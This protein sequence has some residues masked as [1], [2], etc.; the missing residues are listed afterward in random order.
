[1]ADFKASFLDSDNEVQVYGEDNIIYATD[2]SNYDTNTEAGHAKSDFSLYRLLTLLL[3]DGRV[4]QKSSVAEESTELIE[5]VPPVST[6]P[7]LLSQFD[8]TQYKDWEYTAKLY[9]VPTWRS[10]VTYTATANHCVYVSGEGGGLF[11]AL[12]STLNESPL[13]TPAK[14]EKL[15]SEVDLPLKYRTEIRWAVTYNTEVG[16]I[17][18][19]LQANRDTTGKDLKYLPDNLYF[20]TMMKLNLLL[21]SVGTLVEIQDWTGVRNCITQGKE[22]LNNAGRL[23][24]V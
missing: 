7:T 19:V 4:M 24:A 23:N 8:I 22:I 11:K 13:T 14:W 1:M 2:T 17:K 15:D 16:W 5:V 6:A 3:P 12:G 18:S 20:L 9:M 10:D 21:D